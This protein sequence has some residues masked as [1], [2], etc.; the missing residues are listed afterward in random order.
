MTQAIAPEQCWRRSLAPSIRP[1]R[2]DG[3]LHLIEWCV[4][5]LIH[6]DPRLSQKHQRG[7]FRLLMTQLDPSL[8]HPCRAGGALATVRDLS[9]AG[10]VKRRGFRKTMKHPTPALG[11]AAFEATLRAF[12][13]HRSCPE[14]R[15]ARR[16]PFL[17]LLG[18]Q[19]NPN[20]AQP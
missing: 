6:A 1:P 5:W 15:E 2:S 14:M 4:L 20:G 8:A 19:P 12:A 11:E 7:R 3:A 17:R 10:A 18:V 16:E 9:I 13:R